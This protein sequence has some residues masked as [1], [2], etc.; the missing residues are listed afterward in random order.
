MSVMLRLFLMAILVT[1]VSACA[2][3]P[4][5]PE[6]RA[7]Y[8]ENNDPL[9][10]MNRNIF[11]FNQFIDKAAIRPAAQ[12]YRFV[13]PEFVRVRIGNVLSNLGE[14]VNMANNLLQGNPE[15]AADSA[16]RF[17]MNTTVGL[18]GMHDVATGMGTPQRSADFGQ[19]L[20]VWGVT[21][22]GPYLVLPLIGPSNPRDGIGLG[23]DIV[24][25]PWS[26][27][28][29]N[30]LTN[31]E[32]MAFR[33]TRYGLIVL[34]RREQMLDVMD[35]LER[36]SFDF[37]AQVRS[38]YKQRRAKQLEGYDAATPGFANWAPTQ[39]GSASEAGKAVKKKK[40][41]LPKAVVPDHP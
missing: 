11:A 30:Q 38:L 7:I 36:D 9:E 20:Y 31:D 41:K 16:A 3:P 25:D 14:P 6:D 24:M 26:Y 28:A 21:D 18:L 5:D 15:Y 33:M 19:T 22:G 27:V 4:A 40:K 34:D 12:L 8:D 23:V 37:Y 2:T 1:S 29:N 35:A 32:S 39:A 13:L 10:P 17:V